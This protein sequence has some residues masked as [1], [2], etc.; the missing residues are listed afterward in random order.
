MTRKR[1]SSSFIRE[2]ADKE[3]IDRVQIE[4]YIFLLKLLKDELPAVD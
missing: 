4:L 1:K 3:V 2:H